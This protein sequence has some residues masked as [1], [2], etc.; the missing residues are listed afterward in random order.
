MTN[1]MTTD[2]ESLTEYD[3]INDPKLS[4]KNPP[5]TIPLEWENPFQT[6]KNPQRNPLDE[7]RVHT[8]V[9]ASPSISLSKLDGTV[10]S[11]LVDH[12]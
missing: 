10:Y 7:Q 12:S 9:S 3:Q 6:D 5:M 1:N 11:A 8:G 4:P 2:N